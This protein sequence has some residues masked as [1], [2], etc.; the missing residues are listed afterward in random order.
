MRTS[1]TPRRVKNKGMKQLSEIRLQEVDDLRAKL[2]KR[3][4]KLRLQ[5]GIGKLYREHYSHRTIWD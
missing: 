4:Q 2:F 3:Y 5:S 1:E